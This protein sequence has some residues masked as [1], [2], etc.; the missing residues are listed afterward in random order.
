MKKFCNVLT[1]CAIVLCIV[2]IGVSIKSGISKKNTDETVNTESDISSDLSDEKDDLVSL[3]RKAYLLGENCLSHNVYYGFSL[4]EETK[5]KGKN[6]TSII[7]HDLGEQMFIAYYFED[8]YSWDIYLFDYSAQKVVASIQDFSLGWASADIYNMGF[9]EYSPFHFLQNGNIACYSNVELACN[10]RIIFLDDKSLETTTFTFPEPVYDCCISDDGMVAY[11]SIYET[12]EIKKT[13]IDNP[14]ETEVIYTGEKNAYNLFLYNNST[15]LYFEPHEENSDTKYLVIDVKIGSVYKKGDGKLRFYRD[16]SSNI[17]IDYNEDN[18]SNWSLHPCSFYD[19]DN[20]IEKKVFLRDSYC[21]YGSNC[22]VGLSFSPEIKMLDMSFCN[23]I[24]GN[25]EN[26]NY[27]Y[28]SSFSENTDYDTACSACYVPR[29]NMVFVGILQNGTVDW[30]IWDLDGDVDNKMES[31][32]FAYDENEK[33]DV[34]TL[35]HDI[36]N[37]Y[38][39]SVIYDDK[40]VEE[41]QSEDGYSLIACEDEYLLI[42]ALSY[43]DQTLSVLPADIFKQ[44]NSDRDGQCTFYLCQKI[45][46]AESIED[47][48]QIDAAGYYHLDNNKGCIVLDVTSSELNCVVF[49]EVMHEIQFYLEDCK[50]IYIDS[51][52]WNSMNPKDFQYFNSY[53]YDKADVD[54]VGTYFIRSYSK[55]YSCEDIATVMEYALIQDDDIKMMFHDTGVLYKKGGWIKKTVEY[56]FDS[57][58]WNFLPEF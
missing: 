36:E 14:D 46:N 38:D 19:F 13:A 37:K 41:H 35:C 17:M 20:N 43:L 5:E 44:I 40:Q 7:T 29:M 12:G 9:T 1:V 4:E 30:M 11:Y 54:Y 21:F 24:S 23:M 15:Y 42:N 28:R 33:T 48:D 39:I 3:N 22:V 55:T 47:E 50:D 27:V 49:H 6:V 18:Y 31:Y 56:G 58:E 26:R 2:L 45:Q 51:D 8:D 57:K 53:S 34:Q 10:N 16:G 32:K 52:V 25:C